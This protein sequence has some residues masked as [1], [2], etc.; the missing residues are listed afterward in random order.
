MVLNIKRKY[1]NFYIF[2]IIFQLLSTVHLLQFR[3]LLN[4]EDINRVC[5][6]NNKNYK[7]PKNLV[8]LNEYVNS[9]KIDNNKFKDNIEEEQ[10]IRNLLIL[11]KTKGIKYYFS[12]YLYNI[13]IIV[14][15]LIIFTWMSFIVCSLK[16]I[17]LFNKRSQYI[18]F[19]KYSPLISIISYLIILFIAVFSFL[20]LDYFFKSFNGSTCSLLNFFYHIRL[21]SKNRKDL[22]EHDSKKLWPGLLNIES[23]L[24]DTSSSIE[25]ISDNKNSSFLNHEIILKKNSEFLEILKELNNTSFSLSNPNPMNKSKIFPIYSKFFSNISN[26]STLIGKIYYDY[27]NNMNETTN[28][29][30]ELFI[31]INEISSKKEIFINDINETLI[32]MNNFTVLMKNMSSVVSNN[33]LNLYDNFEVLLWRILDCIHFLFIIL[34]IFLIIFLSIYIK[35]KYNSLKIILHFF[36][37]LFLLFLIISGFIGIIL[38][39]IS[40]LSENSIPIFNKIFSENYLNS[41]ESLFPKVTNAAR[42]LDIC[43]N[44]DGDLSRS[45]NLKDTSINELNEYLRILTFKQNK[46]N[47]FI[48]LQDYNKT[49]K[50]MNN[51]LFDFSKSTDDSY[52]K[53]NID[54][55]LDEITELTNDNIESCQ[56][57]D[58]WVSIKENCPNNYNYIS[59]NLINTKQKDLKYCLAITDDYSEKDIKNIYSKVCKNE[60]LHQIISNVKGLTNYYKENEKLLKKISNHLIVLNEKNYEL[61]SMINNEEKN[62]NNLINLLTEIYLPVIGRGSIYQLFNCSVIKKDIIIFYDQQLNYFS[63]LSKNIGIYIIS[64]CLISYFSTYFIILSIILNSKESKH[65]LK[66]KKIEKDD[67]KVELIDYTNHS[68][69]EDEKEDEES[70]LHN[71]KSNI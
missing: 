17:C 51:Y 47:N 37:F 3:N 38:I 53:S 21:G 59:K 5:N 33:F 12:D 55:L 62:V 35:K 26:Q 34:S 4:K 36:L 10:L 54:F 1:N 40:K 69:Q 67:N 18:K 56:S 64:C 45:L 11:G 28:V 39:V 22:F 29:L 41:N 68:I 65:Y 27:K 9:L 43:L 46:I 50:E 61:N 14:F 44:Q 24:I 52:K 49:I 32:N 31:Y 30:N 2:V 16:K 25:E 60:Y 48:S 13:I 23:Y 42:Y 15:L 19:G 6:N 70:T 66:N 63:V 57:N 20:K 71:D 58:I 8:S 7:Q